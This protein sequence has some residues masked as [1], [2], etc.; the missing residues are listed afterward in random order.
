ME[1]VGHVSSEEQAMAVSRVCPQVTGRS[2]LLALLRELSKEQRE[3]PVA[4]M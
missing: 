4:P 1:G 2:G 3:C